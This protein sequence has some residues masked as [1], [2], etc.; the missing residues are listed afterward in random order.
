MATRRE[1]IARLLTHEEIDYV[2][3]P[4]AAQATLTAALVGVEPT[5]STAKRRKVHVNYIVRDWFFDMS[6]QWKTERRWDMQHCLAE[7]RRL[8]PRMFDRINPNT[9]YRWNWSAPAEAPL[10]RRTL[11]PSA[12]MI[13]LSEH[14]MRVSD[15]LCLSAVTIRSLVHE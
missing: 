4:H 3:T 12:D 9:L 15:V 14:I 10:G 5:G 13:R 7:V 8:C 2:R 1:T 11:L 6:H